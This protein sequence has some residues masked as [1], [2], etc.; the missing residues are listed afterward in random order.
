[1]GYSTVIQDLL[2][3]QLSLIGISFSIFTILYSLITSKLELLNTIS[4][5]IKEGN[6]SP[7]LL[8]TENFCIKN[9]NRLRR[10]NFWAILVCISSILLLFFLWLAKLFTLPK[11]TLSI[12]IVANCIDF[13]GIFTLICFV[14]YSYFRTAK[15]E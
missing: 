12:I 15:F 14:F 9:I 2:S 6:H 7:D 10:M 1:M 8:Q 11:I 4:K 13:V 3:V 5:N